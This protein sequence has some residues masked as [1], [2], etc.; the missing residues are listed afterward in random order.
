MGFNIVYYYEAFTYTKYFRPVAGPSHGTSLVEVN[1]AIKA[2]CCFHILILK[3]VGGPHL[4]EALG[5]GLLG[6]CLK[7]ALHVKQKV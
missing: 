7:R 2:C 1:Q 6:L 5:P 3:N 4:W